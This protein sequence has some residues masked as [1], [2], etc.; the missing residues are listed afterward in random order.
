M[1]TK[2]PLVMAK[3]QSIELEHRSM[4]NATKTELDDLH[5]LTKTYLHGPV[6]E[7]TNYEIY[8]FERILRGQISKRSASIFMEKSVRWIN[9]RLRAFQNEDY[10]LV[11]DC[12]LFS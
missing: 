3:V 11:T 7:L 4:N 5:R 12:K 2:W 9:P 8:I 1:K 10:Q 6:Y